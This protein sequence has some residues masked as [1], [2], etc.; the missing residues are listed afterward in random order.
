MV[1]GN[2]PSNNQ[3]VIKQFNQKQ[4]EREKISC[5]LSNSVQE[6]DLEK[7]HLIYLTQKGSF[8][9]ILYKMIRFL[10]GKLKKHTKLAKIVKISIFVNRLVFPMNFNRF[11]HPMTLVMML[12]QSF[13]KLSTITP[14]YQREIVSTYPSNGI[15]LTFIFNWMIKLVNNRI[16]YVIIKVNYHHRKLKGKHFH[17]TILCEMNHFIVF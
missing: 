2:D 10:S 6:G 17:L 7:G 16:S 1:E 4:G 9:V 3:A 15:I 12:D 11:S 5:S 14:T 8:Q 13:L